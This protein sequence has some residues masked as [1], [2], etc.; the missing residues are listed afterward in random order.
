MKNRVYTKAYTGVRGRYPNH[1]EGQA[2]CPCWQRYLLLNLTTCV[3]SLG[4]TEQPPEGKFLATWPTMLP[5]LSLNS[6]AGSLLPGWPGG[7][8]QDFPA[9]LHVPF[10]FPAQEKESHGKLWVPQAPA[11]PTLP[12]W[13]DHFLF[14]SQYQTNRLLLLTQGQKAQMAGLQ[15]AGT[16]PPHTRP[17]WEVRAPFSWYV[18]H[19]CVNLE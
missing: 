10:C 14:L 13:E 18:I 9:Y 6:D 11:Q 15:S 19:S 5:K 8:P 1:G 16:Q 12:S 7:D 3:Q 2:R 4:P 17:A